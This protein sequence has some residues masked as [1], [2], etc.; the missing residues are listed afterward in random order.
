MLT[1][2]L[3]RLSSTVRVCFPTSALILDEACVVWIQVLTRVRYAKT[4][5]SVQFNL[6]LS[7]GDE[8]VEK[9]ENVVT[10]VVFLR[11]SFLSLFRGVGCSRKSRGRKGL[12][13]RFVLG[14]TNSFS[15][16]SNLVS[17]LVVKITIMLLTAACPDRSLKL[18]PEA[19]MKTA[20]CLRSELL[21]LKKSLP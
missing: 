11:C 17:E 6:V 7:I 9:V 2:K 3:S 15:S 18:Q 12:Y 13:I 21:L 16:D 5:F 19:L 20:K 1:L 8:N 10:T 14:T 4:G